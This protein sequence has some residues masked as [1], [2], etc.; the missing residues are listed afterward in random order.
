[1]RGFLGTSNNS[2]SITR[3]GYIDDWNGSGRELILVS[4]NWAKGLKRS[5]IMRH[6]SKAPKRLR[7]RS[8]H[9]TDT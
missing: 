3:R 8:M 1:V 9:S 2:C 5:G 6:G 4:T 7:M